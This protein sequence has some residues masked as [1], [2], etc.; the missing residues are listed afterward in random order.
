[1]TENKGRKNQGGFF[2]EDEEDY[3]SEK[4]VVDTDVLKKLNEKLRQEEEFL[5]PELLEEVMVESTPP[6]TPPPAPAAP[7]AREKVDAVHA[8]FERTEAPAAKGPA[9]EDKT[10]ILAD[11]DIVGMPAVK[12]AKLLV[13]EGP[14]KGKEYSIVHSDTFVGRDTENDFVIADKSISRKHF[15]IRR[16]FDEYIIVDLES[17]NGTRIANEKV[18]EAVLKHEDV[19]VL[20]RTALQFIDLA[21]QAQGEKPAIAPLTK[22]K[23]KVEPP[24]VA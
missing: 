7:A 5:E 6:V 24:V 18:T 21:A 17:G 11:E 3:L 1:M 10:V 20:G 13:V 12:G 14:E 16:R 23:P 19:I 8:L 15:R 2:D 4:T 22:D 9:D